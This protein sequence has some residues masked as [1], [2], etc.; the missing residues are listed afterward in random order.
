VDLEFRELTRYVTHLGQ[1]QE[2]IKELEKNIMSGP[3]PEG[4]LHVRPGDQVLI[5][6]WQERAPQDQLPP[7][8][9]GIYP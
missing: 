2:A 3:Q 9:K 4:E 6:T 8:W 5:H 1:L 7:K